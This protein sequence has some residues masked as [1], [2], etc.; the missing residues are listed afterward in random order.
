MVKKWDL[1]VGRS[2]RWRGGALENWGPL[3]ARSAGSARHFHRRIA[4][5]CGPPLVSS[6]SWPCSLPSMQPDRY[7]LLFFWISLCF[8]SCFFYFSY[9]NAES[10]AR[11]GTWCCCWSTSTCSALSSTFCFA[12][13]RTVTATPSSRS[14]ILS[15]SADVSNL[16]RTSTPFYLYIYLFIYFQHKMC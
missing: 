12:A 5:A 13:S 8:L 14:A 6:S 3:V 9:F 2:Q 4:L 15:F 11:C 7:F 16:S 10:A 1:F